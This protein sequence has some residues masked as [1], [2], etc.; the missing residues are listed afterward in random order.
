MTSN[1]EAVRTI[2]YPRTLDVLENRLD[3]HYVNGPL[4]GLGV[5]ILVKG[6]TQQEADD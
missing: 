1:N 5:I 2:L 3:L 4:D 6:A